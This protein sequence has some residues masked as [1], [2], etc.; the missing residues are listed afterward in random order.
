MGFVLPS[1]A[2][3]GPALQTGCKPR[4]SAAEGASSVLLRRLSFPVEL[5]AGLNCRESARTLPEELCE[6]RWCP[7]SPPW[8]AAAGGA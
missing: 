5:L 6:E 8:E 2:A 3:L 1:V 7:S 4:R